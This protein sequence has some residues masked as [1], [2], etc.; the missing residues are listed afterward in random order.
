MHLVKMQTL[1]VLL[2]S[3]QKYYNRYKLPNTFRTLFLITKKK[4]DKVIKELKNVSHQFDKIL[5]WRQ[6]LLTE[7]F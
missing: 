1:E 5:R 6:N 4:F 3:H 2:D 7:F